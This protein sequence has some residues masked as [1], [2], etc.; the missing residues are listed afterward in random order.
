MLVLSQRNFPKWQ[1]PKCAI[2]QAATFP[3]SVLAA[4]LG[5]HGNQR[6]LKCV[7]FFQF[8]IDQPVFK[9]AVQINT[10]TYY[11]LNTIYSQSLH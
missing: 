8:Q 4:A 3:K 10:C 11:L 6:R 9:I 1:L 7:T 2:S 5:P